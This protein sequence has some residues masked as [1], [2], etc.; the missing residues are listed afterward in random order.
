M[1][2]ILHSIA[3]YVANETQ[4]TLAAPAAE[5][6]AEACPRGVL[7]RVRSAEA[8]DSLREGVYTALM[9]LVTGT[10]QPYLLD[11]TLRQQVGPAAPR[12]TTRCSSST[13]LCR[14]S[15]ARGAFDD[16]PRA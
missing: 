4:C 10:V 16:M 2:N 12:R 7:P 14:S 13:L 8:G 11:Y 15:S 5:A 3:V 6:E 9:D 1:A